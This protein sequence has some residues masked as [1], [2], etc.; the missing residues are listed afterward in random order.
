MT[1][2]TAKQHALRKTRLVTPRRPNG[3]GGSQLA[4]LTLTEELCCEIW[5]LVD[6]I[7]LADLLALGEEQLATCREDA[8]PTDSPPV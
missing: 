3:G 8:E 6:G 7:A 1:S 2:F 4:T 5:M